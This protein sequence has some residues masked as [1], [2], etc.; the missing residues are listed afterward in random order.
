VPARLTDANPRYWREYSNLQ[1]TKHEL[2][3]KYLGGWFAKLGSWAGRVVYL[4]THAGRGAHATGH[5][6]S[7]LVALTTLL[8]HS[9]RDRLLQNCEFG[10]YFIER[11]EEN[12]RAL[13]A[14]ISALGTLPRNIVIESVA[15]DCFERLRE[16]VENLRRSGGKMAPAFVFVDP[17]GFKV[18]CGVLRDLMQSGSVELFI[19]VIWRELDMAIAQ[20][21]RGSAPGFISTLNEIFGGSEWSERI[22][23]SD[24]DERAN[25]AIDLIATKVSARWATSLR[26]LG[27][28]ETTR[29]LLLHLTNHDEGRVL[30]KDCMWSVCPEGGYYARKATSSS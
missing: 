11:D 4:D 20:A 1:R 18:P 26:M 23:S 19:N 10:F 21:R 12:K 24:F 9:H 3:R 13:D 16:I 27:D 22:G 6:G 30:M 28:N 29:Y 2:I 25:Q 14:E 8:R 15:T 17:Y 5:L 7:P